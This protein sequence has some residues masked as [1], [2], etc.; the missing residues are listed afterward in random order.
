MYGKCDLPQPSEVGASVPNGLALFAGIH[1]GVQLGELKRAH[2]AVPHL[3][4]RV[5]L[6]TPSGHLRIWHLRG[7][8]ARRP[9]DHGP[10]LG[11]RWAA[12]GSHCRHRDPGGDD[13]AFRICR[14]VS[15]VDYRSRHPRPVDRRSDLCR[16]C[17]NDGCRQSARRGSQLGRAGD[18][19]CIRRCARGTHGALPAGAHA[20]CLFHP[21]CDLCRASDRRRAHAGID[22]AAR[23]R[24]GVAQAAVQSASRHPATDPGCGTRAGRSMGASRFLRLTR[25][26]ACSE[27]LRAG[28]LTSRWY[29]TVCPGWQRRHRGPAHAATRGAHAD[30]LWRDSAHSRRGGDAHLSLLPLRTGVLPWDCARR[31]WL[32]HGLPSGDQNRGAA[33]CSRGARGC[34]VG[35]LPDLLPRDG[36]S[37]GGRRLLRR[38]A[39]GPIHDCAGA[40]RG[41]HGARRARS[42]RDSQEWKIMNSKPIKIPGPDHPMTITPTE[43]RVAATVNGKRIADTR[44]ALTLKEAAYP[45]VQYIPRKDVDMTQ[46][47]RT[48]HRTYCPYKGECTYYSIPAGGERSANAVWSYEAPHAAASAIREY[49]AF[50][51]ERVDAIEVD[52]EGSGSS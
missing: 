27:Q 45:P 46:L 42:H 33:S 43:G 29:G 48:A 30:D 16:R 51:P 44:E 18:W 8:V 28:F 14:W 12:P 9:I 4:S 19:Y 11:L 6:L 10:A 32:R 40:W 47:Q 35:D 37:G 52:S 7:S 39:G 2:A 38:A 17:G 34:A 41:R 15:H 31:K 5:G 21:G 36:S 25:T 26:V 49:L 24:D 23:R 20:P 13:G 1:H 50:Y 22:A 3:P